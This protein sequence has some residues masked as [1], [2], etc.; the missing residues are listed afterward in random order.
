MTVNTDRD[1]NTSL[2]HTRTPEKT[3]PPPGDF[4]TIYV[5]FPGYLYIMLG[6]MQPALIATYCRQ[7]IFKEI[8]GYKCLQN[9]GP[10]NGSSEENQDSSKEIWFGST[11]CDVLTDYG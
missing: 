3:I 10:K 11:Y 6:F 1:R 9:I 2:A 4:V 5:I 8:R 7:Q